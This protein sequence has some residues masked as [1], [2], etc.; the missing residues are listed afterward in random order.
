MDIYKP[1]PRWDPWANIP[2][3]ERVGL[4]VVVGCGG[5]KLDRPAPAGQMYVGTFHRLCRQA[6]ERLRPD[7]LFILSAKY[8][9]VRPDHYIRPYDIRIGDPDQVQP[10]RLERQAKKEGCW[11]ADLV[12]VLAGHAY[13]DLTRTVWPDAVAPLAGARGIGEMRAILTEI[14]DKR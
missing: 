9:L 13:V 8:G 6:A 14:R 11:Y 1:S 12:I 5:A 3:T 7:R 2:E 4:V 10:E